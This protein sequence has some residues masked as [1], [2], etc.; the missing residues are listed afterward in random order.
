MKRTIPWG[1]TMKLRYGFL[2]VLPGCALIIIGLHHEGA[3][4]SDDGGMDATPSFDAA[5]A[6]EGDGAQPALEGG[7][8]S[9]GD[10]PVGQ[11]CDPMTEACTN[12]CG[13]DEPLQRR[14]LQREHV[15]A[16]QYLRLVRKPR[17]S[18]QR[19]QRYHTDLHE[20]AVHGVVHRALHVRRRLLL[21][22][23][24]RLRGWERPRRLLDGCGLQRLHL[25]QRRPPV[26]ERPVWMPERSRLPVAHGVRHED[27]DVRHRVPYPGHDR[28]QRRLLQSKHGRGAPVLR[29]RLGLCVRRRRR[30]VLHVRRVRAG[31]GVQCWPRRHP[32]LQQR[33]VRV[34]RH[35]P[36]RRER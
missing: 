1:L 33:K 2:F 8:I 26:P 20:R 18:V 29:R 24:R 34:L 10:C 6:G 19:L 5:D 4:S 14:L 23:R 15:R 7:C 32:L 22:A 11:A 9:A 16:R 36:V 28:L 31:L 12:V 27:R 30:H 25:E 3:E 21:R 17:R 35:H 13:P